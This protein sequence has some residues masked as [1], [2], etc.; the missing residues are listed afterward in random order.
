MVKN[1]SIDALFPAVAE[2]TEEDILNSLVG[3]R[4]GMSGQ[5][6]V[7]LPGFTVNRLKELL[8]KHLVKV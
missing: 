5:D 3:A 8:A 1:E 4:E 7:H 6:W 2:A